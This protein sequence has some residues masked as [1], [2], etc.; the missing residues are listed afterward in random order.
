MGGGNGLK[1]NMARE[2]HLKN[3]PSDKGSQKEGMAKVTFA[4]LCSNFYC[5]SFSAA[6][7]LPCSKFI[8]LPP[9]EQLR[10]AKVTF[11][12]LYSP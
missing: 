8:M 3:A 2:R 1:S 9:V 12:L 7:L 10:M 4:L 11:A 6:P 5:P